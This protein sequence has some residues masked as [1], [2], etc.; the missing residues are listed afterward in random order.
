LEMCL[1]EYEAL[2]IIQ[3]NSART[4]VTFVDHNV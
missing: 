2:D 3:I 1:E 4:H